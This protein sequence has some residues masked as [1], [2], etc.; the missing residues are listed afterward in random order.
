[1]SKTVRLYFRFFLKKWIGLLNIVIP[2]RDFIVRTDG[3]VSFLKLTP[4]L[5]VL[6]LFALFGLS[7]WFMFASVSFIVKD[8]VIKAKE[9]EI[10]KNR[11]IY[12]A[13]LSEVS[14]YQ[15]KFS[16]L[17]NDMEKSHTLMLSLVGKNAALKQ[18]LLSA[19]NKLVS[20]KLRQKVISNARNKLTTEL[21]GIQNRMRDLSNHNF[22]LKGSLSSVAGD[23]DNAVQ[24]R[25]LAVEKNEKLEVKVKKLTSQI[26]KLYNSEI[27]LVARLTKLTEKDINSLEHAVLLTGIFSSNKKKI[28]KNIVAFNNLPGRKPSF[29]QGG[30]FVALGT[31]IEQGELLSQELKYLGRNMKKLESLRKLVDDMPLSAPL[32]YFSVSSHYGKRRDPINKR[33]AMHYGLDF[34]GEKNANVYSV[35]RGKVKRAGY[36]GK[37]GNYIEIEHASGFATR[38]GH[39]SK[40]LVKKGQTVS[41]RQK[42]GLMGNTGRSTGNHLHYEI[43]YKGRNKNPWRFIK[44]GKFV[45]KK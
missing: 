14:E 41:F 19:E 3:R 35:A 5:Q 13:L 25:N 31:P 9:I 18:N 6:G 37:Y 45:Y 34:V 24:E 26:S 27:D 23:L 28:N 42:I 39:L 29:N 44:A 11:I 2:N 10:V 16:S 12:R 32:D 4:K 17:M 22:Q 43:V 36:F 30:P 38:Y 1:M 40:I 15:G 7:G 21:S 8:E 20:S 33:W